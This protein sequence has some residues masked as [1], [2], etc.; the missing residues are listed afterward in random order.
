MKFMFLAIIFMFF[1]GAPAQA[2]NLSGF[3]PDKDQPLEITADDTLEWHRDSQQYIAR[4]HVVARQGDVTIKADILTADYRDKDGKNFDIYRLTAAGHV[5][6]ESRGNNAYGDKA[7]YNVD[8]GVAVMTGD[9]LRMVSSDKGT[10]Q[11]LT[12]R[13]SFEYWVNAGRFNAL[14][15]AKIIHGADILTADSMTA[16]LVEG[17]DGKQALDRVEAYNNVVITT[18]T[19]V[20][21]GDKGVYSAKTNIAEMQGSV[22]IERGP[23]ILEGARAEIDL[24]TNVSKMHGGS[25]VGATGTSGGDT[26]VRGVFYPG[27]EKK[28][29]AVR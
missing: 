18:P 8:Q 13:D 24:T 26:R 2:Q 16:W 23:N 29:G 20:L 15:G 7:V 11:T 6:I 17:A 22:R 21:R 25:A 19:E 9:D 4:G 27:S 1:T 5:I 14:G 10:T 28:G 12:A 3:N